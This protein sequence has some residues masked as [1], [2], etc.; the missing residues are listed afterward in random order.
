MKDNLHWDKREKVVC[1]PGSNRTRAKARRSA[2][3]LGN[4]MRRRTE[5][6]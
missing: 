3:R 6:F 2:K 1:G 4:R 5:E